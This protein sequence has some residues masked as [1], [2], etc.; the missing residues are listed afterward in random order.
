MACPVCHY[1]LLTPIMTSHGVVILCCDEEGEI[2]FH[3]AD[4]SV[5]AF[6][7]P[8]GE[9]GALLAPPVREATQDELPASWRDFG[10]GEY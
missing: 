2:W 4:V 9:D 6:Y 1:G 7:R 5:D 10:W 3:P 8:E